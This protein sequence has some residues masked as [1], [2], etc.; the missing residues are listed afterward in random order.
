[1]EFCLLQKE[2]GLQDGS[3]VTALVDALAAGVELFTDEDKKEL[4]ASLKSNE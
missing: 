2:K 3:R 4:V 1:M